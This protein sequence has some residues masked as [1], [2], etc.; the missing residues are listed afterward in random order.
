MQV[1]VLAFVL[2]SSSR[3]MTFEESG[4]FPAFFTFAMLSLLL[5]CVY[6]AIYNTLSPDVRLPFAVDEIAECAALLLLS[7]GFE[8]LLGKSKKIHVLPLLFSV[9]FMGANIALW[10]AWSGEW[11][12]DIVFG[13][14]YI[15]FMYLLLRGLHDTKALRLTE[16]LFIAF[17]ASGILYAMTAELSAPEEY[18]LT[19]D[20][21][22]LIVSVI[23]EALLF[24]KY[25]AAMREP[26]GG[27]KALF[28]SLAI[29]FWTILVT[30]M[31]EDILYNVALLINTISLPF[32]LLAVKKCC[33]SKGWERNERKMI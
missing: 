3:L 22:C 27:K 24:V 13:L 20:L 33:P 29:V 4:P 14:P 16:M 28:L 11:G 26:E 10:I 5:S 15:Y 8:I 7:A 32:T 6:N 17:F 19:I 2:V 23:I 9:M 30:Y 1:I 25:F 31:N 18:A 21:S 12:Q